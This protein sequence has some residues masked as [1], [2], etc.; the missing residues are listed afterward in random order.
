MPPMLPAND[1]PPGMSPSKFE[2]RIRKK[3]VASRPVY[4]GPSFS[5]I[6]STDMSRMNSRPISMTPVNRP[7]GARSA[8][9][10]LCC[11]ERKPLSRAV[12]S[13]DPHHRD[14][15]A[16]DEEPRRVVGH[17]RPL[18][19]RL[20]VFHRVVAEAPRA[21]AAARRSSLSATPGIPRGRLPPSVQRPKACGVAGASSSGPARSCTERRSRPR[22]RARTA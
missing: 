19:Y 20:L 10:P 12:R 11:G 22:R 14:H 7:A 21:R 1:L 8:A 15:H 17:D 5:P 9:L 18:N 6:T 16:R 2:T 4:L 13:D 3:N